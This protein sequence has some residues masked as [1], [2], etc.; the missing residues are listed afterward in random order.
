M[1]AFPTFKLPWIFPQISGIPH[2]RARKASPLYVA[3]KVRNPYGFVIGKPSILR[4]LK[5][6]GK[7]VKI[8]IYFWKNGENP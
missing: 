5:N 2:F 6:P 8:S 3:E 1:D 7:P 4:G